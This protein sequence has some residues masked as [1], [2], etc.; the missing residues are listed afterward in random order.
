VWVVVHCNHPRELSSDVDEALARLVDHGI[1]TL[2]Q[3]VLLAGVND[4]A[5][6]LADLSRALVE[7][8]VVPY[9][10]HVTDRARGNAHLRVGLDRAVELH[11]AL[12]TRVS[13]VALPRLVVDPPEGTGKVD[14]RESARY[15]G[16]S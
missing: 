2:N 7:R 15:A 9:Y 16:V 8:R 14:A 4:D 5:D 10:L 3:S 1:P 11:D 12:R 13:G 6:T